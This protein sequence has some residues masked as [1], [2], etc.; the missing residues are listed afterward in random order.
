MGAGPLLEGRIKQIFTA[1]LSPLVR[2]LASAGLHPNTISLVGVLLSGTAGIMYSVG[3]FLPAALLVAASGICDSLDGLLARSSGKASSYGAFL[4]STLDR[5][6]E[7]LVFL[8]LAWFFSSGSSHYS[9]SP[10]TVFFIILAIE[11]S[12]MVSYTRA[13]AE[14]LGI[15]CMEGLMQRPERMVLII[16]GSLLGSL[17]AIG[18]VAIQI[19]IYCLA[20]LTNL[21]VVQ[22]IIHTRNEM[23]RKSHPYPSNGK[24]DCQS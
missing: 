11:G 3:L 10:I 16:G 7:V 21:T 9:Q 18:V 19:T 15:S 17:A 13:R 2:L 14:A 6:G 23:T 5:V 4:D 12:F 20:V 24:R 22:R 1:S 8:G